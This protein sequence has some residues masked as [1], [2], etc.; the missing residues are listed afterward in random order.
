MKPYLFLIP[1]LDGNYELIPPILKD[2]PNDV[3]AVKY[4]K[5]I[6]KEWGG[7]EIRLGNPSKYKTMADLEKQFEKKYKRI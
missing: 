6:G 3:D 4:A 5:T 7:L 1:N 2:F